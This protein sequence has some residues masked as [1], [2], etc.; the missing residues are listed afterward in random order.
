MLRSCSQLVL[1]LSVKKP[2]AN[3][4]V[5]GIGGTSWSQE[6]S[7]RGK[8]NKDRVNHVS[9]RKAKQPCEIWGGVVARGCSYRW[10]VR[11]V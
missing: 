8:E 4:W 11:G 10:V 2:W 9:Q 3:C 7:R 6:A 1:D 5:G